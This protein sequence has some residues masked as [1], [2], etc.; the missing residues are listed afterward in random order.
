MT[1]TLDQSTIEDKMEESTWEEKFARKKWKV[2]VFKLFAGLSVG[3]VILGSGIILVN[4]NGLQW[5]L[6]G[7][8]W[9]F[10]FLPLG[11][12]IT[13]SVILGGLGPSGYYKLWLS[14]RYR[15]FFQWWYWRGSPEEPEESEQMD[16]SEKAAYRQRQEE[17]KTRREFD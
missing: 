2:N 4:Y 15:T 6:S 10:L 8:I 11:L 14:P 13:A 9:G 5:G 1:E 12:W 17:D 16:E 7:L 3:L